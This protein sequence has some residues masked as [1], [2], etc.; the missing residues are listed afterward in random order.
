[1]VVTF[2]D[3]SNIQ[4]QFQKLVINYPFSSKNLNIQQVRLLIVYEQ[5]MRTKLVTS[6]L[7]IV[8]K[9]L[10]MGKRDGFVHK[11]KE[12]STAWMKAI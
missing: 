9:G 5:W 10:Y 8:A 3:L 7:N 1:M 12:L 11:P 4:H 2:V 6:S